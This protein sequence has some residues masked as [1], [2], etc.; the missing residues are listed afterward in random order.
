VTTPGWTQ[1]GDVLLVFIGTAGVAFA[2]FGRF[3]GH[4]GGDILLRMTLALFALVTLLHPNEMTATAF[5]AVVL[6]GTLVGIW[7]HSLVAAPKTLEAPPAEPVAQSSDLDGVL[8]EARRDF[9]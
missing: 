8:A 4:S 3:I 9:G 6:V 2:M 7:R 5:G 1:V